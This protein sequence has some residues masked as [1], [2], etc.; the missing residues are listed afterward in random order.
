MC[1]KEIKFLQDEDNALWFLV[2]S[3]E[4]LQQKGQVLGKRAKDFAICSILQAH[5]NGDRFECNAIICMQ[6]AIQVNNERVV[7]KRF[8]LQQVREN[9][10]DELQ[11]KP[12][13]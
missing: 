6:I 1:A 11:S 8:V 5:L 13:P 10:I 7:H 3:L 9:G 12:E 4:A 2:A